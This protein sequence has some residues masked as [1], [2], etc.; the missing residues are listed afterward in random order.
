[1]ALI[2]CPECK[3]LVSDE[4]P[5]CR[6]CGYAL[7]APEANDGRIVIRRPVRRDSDQDGSPSSDSK[8][9]DIIIT[10]PLV[11]VVVLI[12]LGVLLRSC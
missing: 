1:M 7:K 8:L 10:G 11:L 4:T 5:V 2:A 3:R 9:N 6:H 12:L